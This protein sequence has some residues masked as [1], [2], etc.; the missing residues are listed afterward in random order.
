MVNSADFNDSKNAAGLLKVG[1]APSACSR[2]LNIMKAH[3]VV[4][5]RRDGKVIHY[6]V[7]NPH[8]LNVL[9][10]IRKHAGLVGV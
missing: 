4:S 8:A 10:C 2:H 1:I 9:S 5:S 7:E 3:G 6:K